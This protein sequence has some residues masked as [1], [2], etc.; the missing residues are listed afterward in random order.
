MKQCVFRMVFVSL[1]A[2]ILASCAQPTIQL[3]K[4]WKSP[5]AT[6]RKYHKILVVGS[7][8]SLKSILPR[9]SN[10]RVTRPFPVISSPT[11][12]RRSPRST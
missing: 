6:S 5:E 7:S 2:A 12:V 9:S 8:S 3:V 10:A 4:T 11:R 1:A